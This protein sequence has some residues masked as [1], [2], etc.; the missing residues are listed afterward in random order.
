MRYVIENIEYRMTQDGKV[1]GVVE[2][3]NQKIFGGV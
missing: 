3:M 2:R 1:S